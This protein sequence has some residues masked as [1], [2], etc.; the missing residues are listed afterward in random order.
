M[1]AEPLCYG[2]R[3]RGAVWL[4]WYQPQRRYLAKRLL[5]TQNLKSAYNT[6]S[7]DEYCIYVIPFKVFVK[8]PPKGPERISDKCRNTQEAQEYAPTAKLK[9]HT[10]VDTILTLC[11][12]T[13]A[14]SSQW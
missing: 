11:P 7:L 10:H 3:L 9:L 14:F 6:P 8:Q 5:N 13:Q 2:G 12:I 1:R 4:S